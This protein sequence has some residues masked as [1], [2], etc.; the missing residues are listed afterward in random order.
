MEHEVITAWAGVGIGVGQLL[1][2]AWGFRLMRL[3]TDQRREE[4]HQQHQETMTALRVLIER[5][6]N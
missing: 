3:G 5:T 4:A 2:I 6:G 1:L